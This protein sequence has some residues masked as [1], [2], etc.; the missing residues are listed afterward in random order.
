MKYTLN[1]N[2]H[3]DFKV[4][5]LN[6]YAPRAYAVPFT[7]KK[8]A[9]SADFRTARYSSDMVRVLSGE[10]DFKY[11]KQESKMPD[12]LDTDK[13]KFDKITVP[14]TWQRSGYE[15]PVYLNCPYEFDDVVPPVIPDDMPAG[16]YRK[17]FEVSDLNKKYV[18]TFLGARPCLNVYV[19]GSFAGYGEAAHNSYE[20]D[21][22]KYLTQGENELVAVCFKWANGSYLEAQDMFRENGIFRDVLLYEY[23]STFINDYELKTHKKKDGYTLLCEAQVLGD[24]EGYEVEFSLSKDGKVL[25][26]V[27]VPAAKE[28]KV[29]F[30]ALDVIE[31]NAEIPTLY[32]LAVTLVKGKKELMSIKNMTGFKTVEIKKDVFTF[33]GKKIKMKGVNHHDTQEKTGYVMTVEDLEKD[34]KLMKAL[35]VNT[36]RTSHYPPDPH[37]LQLADFYGLYVV[38]EADIETHGLQCM[39]AQ[40]SIDIISNDLKWAKRYVDRVKRMYYRDRSHP[41]VTMWSLGNESG[42]YKCH[43]K[44]C[45]FLHEAC[46]EI[47]VHYEG[48]CRTKRHCYDVFSEMYTSISEIEKVKNNTRGKEYVGK[49]FYLCEY[50]HAMG[51]GP[52]ALEEYWDL[53]YS[54]DNLMGGCIWEWADHAV[55]HEN[56]KY[57]YKYTYGGDHGEKRHDGNFCVDALVYPDRTPHTGAYEMQ[58]VY[59]PLR[60]AHKS[61][62]TFAFTN[63]N[64]F[65]SSSYIEIYWELLEN[66]EMKTCGSI[67]EDI[68][69][70][71]TAAVTLD[72]GKLDKGK[73][74]HI[75]FTY[76]DGDEVIALEQ[77]ELQLAKA[78]PACAC[79]EKINV[80]SDNGIVTVKFDSGSM[81]FE[82]STGAALSYTVGGRE[83]LN[84]TPAGEKGFFPNVFRALLDNDR[85]FGQNWLK[86]GLDDYRAVLTDFEV[87][88]ED[89]FAEIETEYTLKH[90]NAPLYDVAITYKVGANGV[91]EIDSKL[92]VNDDS[93]N[94]PFDLPR[95]GFMFEMPKKYSAVK[96][97]GRGERENMPDFK[98]QSPVGIYSDNV[99]NM[100]EPY[101]K[102]QD[103]GNHGEVRWLEITD[104]SGTG[105]RISGEKTFSF[106]AHNFTQKLLAGAKHQEDLHDMNTT[107]V[108]VD[109]FVRGTG[110]AS[111]GP[112]T[113]DKYRFS[114]EDSPE[115]K[116]VIEP[117]S[118]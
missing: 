56:D 5:E 112:D 89:G 102:P 113:L 55:L 74:Y 90:K 96:Y 98:A 97:Y 51:V 16:V 95:F 36:V 88:I 72:Y 79:G 114:A 28:T 69:P 47:P 86:A 109:G 22:T 18:V 2:N 30:E 87:E 77:L 14:C 110:T 68:A 33:N 23:P 61:G 70:E 78:A 7:S 21:I 105:I 20:F 64:R 15:P 59:R 25:N 49:P 65:R 85:W 67:C 54:A 34:V 57:K 94:T 29:A 9:L 71:K 58:V 4:I 91:V 66:G 118:K 92:S 111:C 13:V 83:L 115:F 3:R 53:F 6:R 101:V 46:P 73:D 107:V 75:N 24:T 48:V 104:E 84:K 43:D 39:K 93:E 35:N 52:G 8:K 80:V 116:V 50:C 32:D 1:F 62:S 26:R 40:Y 81:K 108:T 117:I 12:V 19:N 44:C 10:W 106:N 38:D 27:Q 45:E 100:N 41:C 60:A 82:R 103:N 63:T 99:A 42:G 17:K 37:F 11:F 31:W 76:L